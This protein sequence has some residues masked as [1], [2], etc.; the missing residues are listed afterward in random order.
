MGR[1]EGRG[2]GAV[3]FVGTAVGAFVACKILLCRSSSAGARAAFPRRNR[4][5]A[6]AGVDAP[7]RTDVPA[8]WP[9]QTRPPINRPGIVIFGV[10]FGMIC[11]FMN[12]SKHESGRFKYG[13]QAHDL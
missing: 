7:S 5:G 6:S 3:V 2:V 11:E 13:C 12:Q 8:T 1:G 10:V 9:N 4:R